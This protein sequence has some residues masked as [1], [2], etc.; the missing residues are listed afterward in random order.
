MKINSK[1]PITT[2]DA[3]GCKVGRVYSI[4]GRTYLKVVGYSTPF[5]NHLNSYNT[6]CRAFLD[7]ET[8]KI[9]LVGIDEKATLLSDEP[10]INI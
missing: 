9:V 1:N 2:I 8:S 6:G 3:S 5:I 4:N 10:E 7:L